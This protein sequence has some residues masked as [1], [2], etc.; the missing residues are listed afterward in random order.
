MGN[1]ADEAASAFIEAPGLW[2]CPKAHWDGMATIS[3]GSDPIVIGNY[4][5]ADAPCGAPR[6]LCASGCWRKNFFLTSA[7]EDAMCGRKV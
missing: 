5:P 7:G 6:Q 1:G 4:P 2:G 3:P